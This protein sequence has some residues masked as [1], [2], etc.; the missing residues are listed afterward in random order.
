M[1]VESVFNKANAHCIQNQISWIMSTIEATRKQNSFGMTAIL[2]Y[3]HT[4]IRTH[5]CIQMKEK[6][7]IEYGFKF[8]L[9][10]TTTM[11]LPW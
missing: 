8:I 1:F 3:R 9:F 5:I 6:T 11:T 10:W 7:G 4:R 2:S